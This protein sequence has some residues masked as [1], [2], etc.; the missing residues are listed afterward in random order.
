MV[1]LKC[2]LR[3]LLFKLNL[4]NRGIARHDIFFQDADFEAFE[5][6]I[7]EGLESFPAD[8]IAYQWMENHW[9]MILSPL[10]DVGMSA[11]IGWTTLTHTQR[12][13]AQ[14]NKKGVED[15]FD[16]KGISGEAKV[17]CLE[18]QFSP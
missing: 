9:H 11:F 1:E 17:A 6:I 10:A 2:D 4:L 18:C 13:H 3:H 8:L 7:S 12:Y 15:R 14:R 5:R 16:E